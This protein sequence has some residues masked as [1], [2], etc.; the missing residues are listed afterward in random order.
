MESGCTV[1]LC[2]ICQALSECSEG[3]ER[4]QEICQFCEPGGGDEGQ[5]YSRLSDMLVGKV[6]ELT[7]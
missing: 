3:D 6:C 1:G 7:S 5:M 4:K 2:C